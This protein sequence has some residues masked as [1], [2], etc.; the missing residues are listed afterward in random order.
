[1]Y[2]KSPAAAKGFG[3]VLH[4]GNRTQFC[5]QQHSTKGA[6]QLS[7]EVQLPPKTLTFDTTIQGNRRFKSIQEGEARSQTAH[8]HKKWLYPHLSQH[9]IL[10]HV[11]NLPRTYFT[12]ECIFEE[13]P[14]DVDQQGCEWPVLLRAAQRFITAAGRRS[15][16][17][18]DYPN[19][20]A[21][22]KR[23]K[24]PW[25]WFDT[26]VPSFWVWSVNWGVTQEAYVYFAVNGYYQFPAKEEKTQANMLILM[27]L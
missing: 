5:Q 22:K 27:N 8:I 4:C 12:F 10:L 26:P 19:N 13:L 11:V 25:S 14:T 7:I 2:T 16:V 24:N 1:M 23:I 9:V 20:Q 17:S 18:Q 15:A 21:C 3:K 6:S